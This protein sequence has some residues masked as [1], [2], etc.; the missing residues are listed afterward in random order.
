M[1]DKLSV[2]TEQNQDGSFTTNWQ[3]C[4]N[5]APGKQPSKGGI[6]T[7]SL[8]QKWPADRKILAELAA[9]HHLLCIEQVH[10]KG[11]MGGNIEIEVSFGAIR[12]ALLKGSIKDTDKGETDKHHVALFAK[13]LATKFFETKISVA[14]ASKQNNLEPKITANHFITVDDVP[15]VFIDS[16]IGKVIISRHALNRVVGRVVAKDVAPDEDDLINVPDS[17]WTNAWRFLEKTL[18]K[19]TQVEIPRKESARI[20]KKYGAGVVALLHYDAQSV[21]IIK[22]T[23][24][25]AEMIT[26]LLDNEYNRITPPRGLPRQMGQRLVYDTRAGA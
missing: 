21:F 5:A 26:M 1:I 9:I 16:A 22:K 4:Q 19:A 18:P 11:R 24:Y 2:S 17:K 7:L 14:Q 3:W 13:F 10:G 8:N 15:G 23:A 20:S 12:K 6:V 25:G